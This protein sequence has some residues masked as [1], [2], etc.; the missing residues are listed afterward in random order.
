MTLGFVLTG[1]GLIVGAFVFVLAARERKL[2]TEGIGILV[3]VGGITGILG[4]RLT[5]L[6]FQTGNIAAA[7]QPSLGGKS[8][9]GG[10]LVGWLAVEITKRILK[11]R[12]STGD[13]FALALPAG[14]AV[15]RLGCLANGCCYGETCNLPWAIHQHGEWRH[16]AQIYSALASGILFVLLWQLRQRFP[17]EGDLFRLYLIGFAITRFVIEFFR[18][19]DHMAGPLSAMQWVCL[20]MLA[21]ALIW[22]LWQARKRPNPVT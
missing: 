19:H 17:R 18:W 9:L 2:D 11:I 6:F 4:A 10:V 3:L 20:E 16:P 12:R 21:A 8:I 7:T 1:L 5:Q 15:G 14:E 13:L 22:Q